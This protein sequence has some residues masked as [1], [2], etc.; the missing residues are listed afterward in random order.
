MPELHLSQIFIK[1]GGSDISTDLMNA[2]RE[3]VVDSSLQLPSMFTL[4]F[5]DPQLKWVDDAL[6]DLGKEVEISAKAL[7]NVQGV[8]IKGEITALEPIFSAVGDTRLVVRG[9]D[10]GHRLHRGKKT[11]TFLKK[12][13]SDLVSKLAGEAGLTPTVDATTVTHDFVLQ[14]NQTNMEF[15]MSRAERIGYQVYSADRKSVV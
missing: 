6:F 14:N 12:K 5:H 7:D 9:Y 11:R 1:V 15:L 2:L 8:L 4:S 3:V 13:D 10:K